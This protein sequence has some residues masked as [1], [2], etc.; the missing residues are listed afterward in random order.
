V[1]AGATVKVYAAA[2][3]CAEA[4]RELAR[5]G[6]GAGDVRVRIVCLPSAEGD[7]R[8]DLATIGA[9]ARRASQ[10]S[11][12]V[13]YIGEPTGAATRF[14]APILEAAGIRQ[15]SDTSGARAMRELLKALG[16]EGRVSPRGNL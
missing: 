10:D 12:T 4:E 8:L 3:L 16:E 11:S 1:E 14:S 5:A 7:G 2:S 9:N 13:A 15:L 6:G